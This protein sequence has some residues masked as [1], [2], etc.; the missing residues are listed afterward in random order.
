MNSKRLWLG[1]TLERRFEFF[2]WAEFVDRALHEVFGNPAGSEIVEPA[3]PS[4]KTGRDQPC[5]IHGAPQFQDHAGSE[6]KS[7]HGPGQVRIPVT[8]ELERGA[9]VFHFADAFIMHTLA[10]AHAA[11]IESKDHCTRAPPRSRYPVN[12]LV[13]HGAAEQGMGMAHET[14]F[15][16][17]TFFWFLEQSFQL[18]GGAVYQERF[19][20]PWHALSWSGS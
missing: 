3:A 12:D 19:D 14:S 11:E 15:A 4:G 8:Q 13:V 10:E 18:A 16:R 2:L 5:G 6:G 1:E 17:L 9:G 7:G 20:A